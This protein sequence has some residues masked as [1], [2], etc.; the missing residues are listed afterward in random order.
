MRYCSASMPRGILHFYFM[1]LC[2]SFS[3]SPTL[4]CLFVFGFLPILTSMG[5]LMPR[6]VLPFLSM[7]RVLIDFTFSPTL[8]IN[9]FYYSLLFNINMV[10]M[11]IITI[12]IT[13]CS[14]LNC[15]LPAIEIS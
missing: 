15:N 3:L 10:I 12:I 4:I 11:I 14:V 5:Y 2:A 6:G 7:T 1:A 8:S 9:F 13:V